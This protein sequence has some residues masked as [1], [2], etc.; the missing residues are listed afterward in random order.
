[1]TELELRAAICETG[2]RLWQRGLVGAAEGNISA[3]LDDKRL[4]CTPSGLSK[5][6]LRPDDIVVMDYKGGVVKGN[7]P[8][9]E[10]KLHL[11]V[12]A[13]RPDCQ[14]VVHAHPAMATGFALA[15]ETVPDNWLPEAAIVLGSVANVPFGM[16]GTEELPAA[17]RP[18]LEDH[19]TFLLS[20]H[21]AV[22]MGNC[23][24]DAYNRMETLERVCQ[25]IANARM[26]GTPRPMPDDAFDHLLKVSLNGRLE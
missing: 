3:R 14:A 17:I 24:T 19:K 12:Y 6:H 4:L 26:V 8:S 16:P 23:L 13:G 1:M 21:G 5:G 20:H 22:V 15:G 11:A 10:V 9:S 25:V 7:A 18:F 2:R